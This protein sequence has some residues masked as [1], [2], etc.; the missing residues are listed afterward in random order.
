[1]IDGEA[2]GTAMPTG[3][4][5]PAD[6]TAGSPSRMTSEANASIAVAGGKV[7]LIFGRRVVATVAATVVAGTTA[8][9]LPKV[10]P[11]GGN[12]DAL[13][14]P[15]LGGSARNPRRSPT[16]SERTGALGLAAAK[17][18]TTAARLTVDNLTAIDLG[19]G[20]ALV[21]AVNRKGSATPR[22]DERLF[23]IAEPAGAALALTMTHLQTITVTEPLL[24]EVKEQ[25][26]D[27][28]DL[29]AG[30]VGVVTRQIGYDAHTYAIYTRS[31]RGWKML[32]TGGGVAL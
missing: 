18:G 12:V 28:I 22:K 31:G 11:L 24:E 21:G 10:L 14:S 17:L 2:N 13:A 15:T 9:T 30:N 7:H 4:F 25:L 1:M 16:T 23:F 26:V 3:A 29:G 19:H 5:M 8:V 32:Y 20:A 6:P 27:A